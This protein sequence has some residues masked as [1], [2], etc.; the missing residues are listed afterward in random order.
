MGRVVV[1][2]NHHL[3]HCWTKLRRCESNCSTPKITCTKSNVESRARSTEQSKKRAT[4]ISSCLRCRPPIPLTRLH[5][6]P[7]K[8]TM[9][10]EVCCESRQSS[11]HDRQVAKSHH[12]EIHHR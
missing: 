2:G 7:I 11:A 4:F 9:V 3:H 1:V 10:L 12:S 8:P 6:P 5:L